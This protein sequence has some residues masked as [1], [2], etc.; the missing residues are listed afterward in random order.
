MNEE[1]I[2]ALLNKTDAEKAYNHKLMTDRETLTAFLAANKI[3]GWPT[4]NRD[5]AVSSNYH[6]GYL[7]FWQGN[8]IG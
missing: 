3:K 1:P 5:N 7:K 4:T 6:A 2:I 8:V